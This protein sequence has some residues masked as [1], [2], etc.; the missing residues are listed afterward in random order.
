MANWNSY[1]YPDSY[2][3]TRPVNFSND[4]LFA[5]SILVDAVSPRRLASTVSVG[6][7]YDYSGSPVDYQRPVRPINGYSYSDPGYDD[8]SGYALRPV[9]ARSY[10]DPSQYQY[11]SDQSWNMRRPVRYADSYRDYDNDGD[12]PYYR[13]RTHY[14]DNQRFR[15]Y[16][17]NEFAYQQRLRQA[18]IMELQRSQNRYVKP[19][20][21]NPGD[22]D[23]GYDPRAGAAWRNYP[24]ELVYRRP[25]GT[26]SYDQYQDPS[27]YTPDVRRQVR[28]TELP[29][30]RQ[31]REYVDRAP[32]GDDYDWRAYDRL[33]KQA[34]ELK[35]QS[36]TDY[37]SRVTKRLGCCRAVSLLLNKAWGIHTDDI[38]VRHM[39]K[40]LKS[41]EGFTQVSIKDMKPGDLILAYRE[42]NDYP[43]AAVYM[44]NGKIFNNDSNE[45]V[46]DIQSVGKFNSPEFKRFV[47]LR[48]PANVPALA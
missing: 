31:Q 44:G 16:D 25:P 26:P 30:P 40:H 6:P 46:M 12:L 32:S 9:S 36:V 15:G 8:Y 39:E 42:E 45:G 34:E 41:T 29:P 27:F 48:R 23:P 13:S 43:H 21:M 37:D 5:D 14:V 28:P 11:L 20:I 3:N 7:S 38:N 35:G 10:V 1:D 33:A 18:E 47:I 4:S 2:A 24:Q 19:Y 17:P 22:Y